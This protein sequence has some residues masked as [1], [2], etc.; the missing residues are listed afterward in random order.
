VLVTHQTQFL[1]HAER[2]LIMDGGEVVADGSF[3]ALSSRTDIAC[4]AQLQ[5]LGKEVDEQA[6][7]EEEAARLAALTAPTPLKG[8]RSSVTTGN[9]KKDNAGSQLVRTEE[10][11]TGRVAGTGAGNER[12]T[13]PLC[14]RRP[15]PL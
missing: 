12:T 3:A 5:E 9:E 1:P 13:P 6:S 4:M 14:R 7:E 11:A 10:K 15:T 8:R 2:I